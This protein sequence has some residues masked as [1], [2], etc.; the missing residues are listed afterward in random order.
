MSADLRRA[1]LAAAVLDDQPVEVDPA[2]GD[3][4]VAGGVVVAGTRRVVRL[5]WE[6][7]SVALGPWRSAP[8]HPVTRARLDAM[9]TAAVRLADAG[10]AGLAAALV[11]HGEVPGSP[12][13]PGQEWAWDR[14]G[15]SALTAGWGIVTAGNVLSVPL[16]PAPG[17]VAAIARARR[18]RRR[19]GAELDGL[20]ASLVERLDRDRR[21]GRDLVLRPMGHADVPTLLL[22]R[23]VREWIANL[24]GTGLGTVAVPTRVRGWVDIRRIDPPYVAAAHAATD[25]LDAASPVP[26][27]VTA[28]R[29][30]LPSSS[31][32]RLGRPDPVADAYRS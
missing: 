18:H 16:P 14:R 2:A 1:V 32:P 17:L 9:I 29:V 22:C 24:D 7:V 20:G 11:V 23:T 26:F 31:L 4:P 13:F 28:D 12:R 5:T 27:L 15:G 6:D 21:E 30:S 19:A 8:S 3:E 25:A 10:P